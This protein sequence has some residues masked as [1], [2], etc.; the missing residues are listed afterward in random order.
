M[1]NCTGEALIPAGD[2]HLS[3]TGID[4]DE[5]AAGG[6][7]ILGPPI[8]KWNGANDQQIGFG[9]DSFEAIEGHAGAL[10]V[11]PVDPLVFEAE[12]F[13]AIA[14]VGGWE[15]QVLSPLLEIPIPDRG[16]FTAIFE[17]VDL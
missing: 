7:I 12:R 13:E 6:K 1:T 10:G 11:S 8:P 3:K 14:H 15:G 17:V 9:A 4:V 16:S 2:V 5:D